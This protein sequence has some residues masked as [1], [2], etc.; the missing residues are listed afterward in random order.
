MSTAL[1]AA[2]LIMIPTSY[3]DGLLAS[4]KPNDGAGDFTFSRGSNL[5]ATRVNE[6]GYIEKGYENLLLQSNSFDT[7]WTTSGTSVTSGQSGYDGSSDAW[8]LEASSD[9]QFKFAAQNLSSS[10]VNTFSCYAKSGTTD[11]IRI[12]INAGSTA[13]AYFDLTAGVSGTTL[14]E[15]TTNIEAVSGATGW[16]RCSLVVND[17]SISSVRIYVARE[18]SVNV[19]T[20]DNIYIQD[21]MLNQGMVAYPYVETTTAPVAGGILEDMPRI[22]FS[23]GNQ[24]LLLE[25]SRTSLIKYSEYFGVG[26]IQDNLS[27]ITND[28]TS[29][30][31]LQNA[32]KVY[33]T[34]SGNYRNIRLSPSQPSSEQITIS[35]FAKAAE[36]DHLVL[37][38]YDGSGVG[39]DFNLSTGVA[40]DSATT[41]FDFVDMVDYGNGW[42]R[43]I[44]TATNPYFYWILSDNG[45]LSVTAN[46]TDGLYIYGAQAEQGSY[47]TSYIPTYGV[48]QTRLEDFNGNDN[49]VSTPISFGANDDFT[50]YYEGSFA[51]IGNQGMIMGGGALGASASSRS[52][53]WVRSSDLY[54]AGDAA[55]AIATASFNAVANTN[56]KLLV[57]RNGSVLDFFVNGAKLTTNQSNP[58]TPFTFRSLGWSY[59]NSAYKIS[60]DIKQALIFPTALSDDEC[61]TLTTI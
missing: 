17:S 32:T 52:Y 60:G 3:S 27:I 9:G 54:L 18:N 53:W 44:A 19:I 4:V 42:Y 26:W 28:A 12:Q 2:S 7:T 36:L 56:Y 29:P 58:N 6:D 37:I 57:K 43:C 33:P 41:D 10:G 25:P 50:L 40:T 22:D 55:T 20:G 1:E 46:G 48:S 35:I 38:D 15:V 34:S 45:G 23:G 51:K 24:S 59:N 14:N 21:A 31:G 30:E 11:Y 61:I 49:I 8:L 47:P 16:Y 39:I 13:F 5:S